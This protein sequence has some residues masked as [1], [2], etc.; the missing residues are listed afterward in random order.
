MNALAAVFL[1]PVRPVQ[2]L[3]AIRRTA[4]G[5]SPSWGVAGGLYV[6]T[7][8][9]FAALP[10]LSPE[11]R[12]A[13]SI[14][15]AVGVG[16]AMLLVSNFFYVLGVDLTLDPRIQKKRSGAMVLRTFCTSG[17]FSL[18]GAIAVVAGA[19]LFQAG[20]PVMAGLLAAVI[21]WQWMVEAVS[22]RDLY[23]ISYP[24]AFGLEAVMR[25]GSTL[26]GGLIGFTLIGDI[27]RIIEWGMGA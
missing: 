23:G 13:G 12:G 16:A 22:I 14:T 17:V 6:L 25:S 20:R 1:A 4:E 27:A 5:A 10:M 19:E 21:W 2:S 15:L 11:V 24:V 18:I 7:T 9:G 8:V 3:P 26:V